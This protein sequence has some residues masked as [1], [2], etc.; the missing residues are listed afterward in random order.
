MS[1]KLELIFKLSVESLRGSRQ[2]VFC[3]GGRL[4]RVGLLCARCSS[5][6]QFHEGIGEKEADGLW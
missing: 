3:S 1:L 4:G 5:K 2:K 6:F